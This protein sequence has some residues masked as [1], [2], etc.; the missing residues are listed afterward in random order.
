MAMMIRLYG[1][2]HYDYYC[3]CYIVGRMITQRYSLL[4]FM[5]IVKWLR[6]Y[7]NMELIYMIKIR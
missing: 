5:V 1:Y 4:L 2:F 3:D 6:C 7:Y